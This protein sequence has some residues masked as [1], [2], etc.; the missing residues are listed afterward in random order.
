MFVHWGGCSAILG[1]GGCAGEPPPKSQLWV[2]C[3]VSQP[4]T[5]IS[6]SLWSLPRGTSV[7]GW[8]SHLSQLSTSKVRATQQLLSKYQ[9]SVGFWG[10]AIHPGRDLLLLVNYGM[11]FGCC[12]GENGNLPLASERQYVTAPPCPTQAAFRKSIMVQNSTSTGQ[13]AAPL[14]FSHVHG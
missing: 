2:P 6:H 1:N 5:N 8:Q 14:Q 11:K 3:Y 10:A 13:T 4:N 9:G 12:E 7:C